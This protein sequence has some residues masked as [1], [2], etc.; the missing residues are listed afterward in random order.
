MLAL[1]APLAHNVVIWTRNDLAQADERLQ[2]F[3]I[4][5]TVRDALQIPGR[6]QV[7]GQGQV[8]QVTLNENHP[9]AA[10]FQTASSNWQNMDHL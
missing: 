10:A 9:L 5:R 6:I 4:Q 1:L 8:E 3:G 2:K 7:K